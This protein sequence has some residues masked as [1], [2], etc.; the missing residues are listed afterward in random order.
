LFG[1]TEFISKQK[2]AEEQKL[3]EAL[4]GKIQDTYK[5]EDA[6]QKAI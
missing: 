6:L 2:Q 1:D 4:K 5:D 3:V